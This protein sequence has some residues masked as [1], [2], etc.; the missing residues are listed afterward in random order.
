MGF[1]V[2]VGPSEAMFVQHL[3]E[4]L[5]HLSPQQVCRQVAVAVVVVGSVG[6]GIVISV[7]DSF[8]K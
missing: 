3:S 8:L 6:R 7:V 1:F 5:A 2:C 4:T